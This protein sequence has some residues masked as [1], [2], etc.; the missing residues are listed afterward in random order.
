MLFI[1]GLFYIY[2]YN[3]LLNDGTI[4]TYHLEFLKEYLQYEAKIDNDDKKLI[5][6]R[7]NSIS[8]I[9]K[10]NNVSSYQGLAKYVCK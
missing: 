7:L 10:R 2:K 3:K 8:S 6:E 9:L 1:I 4:I 5:Q